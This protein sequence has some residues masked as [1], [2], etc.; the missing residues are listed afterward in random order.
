[1][2]PLSIVM[3]IIA[4]LVGVAIGYLVQRY[5]T[6]KAA[7]AKQEKADDILKAAQTQANMIVKGAQDNAAKI[8]KTAEAEVR[9][10][11]VELNKETERLDKRR[12]E[13]DSRFDKMEQREQTLNKRQ[14]QVDKR[15]NDI[16]KLYEEQMK[17]LEFVAQMTTEDARKDL[18]AAVE[19]EARGDMARIIRQIET[20]AREEGEKRAR[21]LIADAI[22]RVASEHVAEVTRAVVTLPSEEMKGRIVGRNGRNIKAFEQAAGVDVIVDDTPDS[23]TVSCFD[24]VRREIGRRALAKLILDG[25]IHPAHIE[26]IIEDETKAVEKII[27]EAGDQ[28]AFEANITGL[29]PEVLR[30]MGRLKFRTSYGQN[31]LA[32]AVEVSKLAGIL[33]AELG[34]NVE[35]S[36][37]GGFLHDIGKAMD[38]NQDGT[39]AGLGAEY[40]KRYGVN[41]IVVNAIASHHHEVDQETVEAVIAEAADAISGARPGA[42]REDL[43]AYIKRIRSLEEMSMSFEGVQQAFAIQAGREVRILVKPDQIDDLAS[44]RLARDIAKKI[45]ETMQYPGQIRVTVIRETRATEYAK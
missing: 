18:F 23:V 37:Q 4:L 3:S 35:L 38:H 42:R 32:H 36:K 31:Q 11:R 28:A 34:A 21:K 26:K 14:S 22:Q 45:E 43:E 24:S 41:P 17:K 30:M 6:E 29:H 8:T 9:E 10:R 5:Q 40:C 13:L 39:H 7:K 44:T 27:N 19:K 2:N 1:M 15:A 16:D 33:A 12:G 20:E 25:R